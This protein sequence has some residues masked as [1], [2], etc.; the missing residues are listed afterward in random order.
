M[1]DARSLFRKHVIESKKYGYVADLPA[2]QLKAGQVTA[3]LRVLIN[4]KKQ[5]TARKLRAY[6]S[7]AYKMACRAELAPKAP[8]KA[9][10]FAVTHNPV[11]DVPFTSGVK[12]RSRRLS[13]AELRAFLPLLRYPAPSN[14]DT[15]V[16]RGDPRGSRLCRQAA[17]LSLT[18]GGQRPGQ[19]LRLTTDDVVDNVVTLYDPKGRRAEPRVH[20]LPLIDEAA[21][22]VDALMAEA[23][24]DAG[25]VE[26]RSTPSVYL[27]S[28]RKDRAKPMRVET[29]SK[30]AKPLIDQLVA[31]EAVPAPFQLRDLRRTAETML[32]AECRVE[33]P[34]RATPVTR[35]GRSA[36][37]ALRLA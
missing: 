37:T 13:E 9:N 17:L 14:G 31:R 27:F 19:V 12:A 25:R 5:D 21:E 18:L 34:P 23:A 20:Q 8:E 11:A 7:A 32:A 35:A 15:E 4:A 33:G 6:W 36:G 22:I 2:N 29:L 28:T 30:W 10:E 16:E 26:R 1:V 3:V 24:V